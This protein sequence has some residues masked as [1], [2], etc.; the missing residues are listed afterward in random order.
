LLLC[1]CDVGIH[2]N[3]IPDTAVAVA[4]AVAIGLIVVAAL[5][6]LLWW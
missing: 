6:L 2:N 1:F 5:L 4:V 3:C